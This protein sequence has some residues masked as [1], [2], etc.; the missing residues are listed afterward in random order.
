MGVKQIK[1]NFRLIF[2]SITLVFCLSCSTLDLVTGGTELV[3]TAYKVYDMVDEAS[4]FQDHWELLYSFGNK[5]AYFFLDESDKKLL[6]R[7]LNNIAGEITA[8]IRRLEKSSS[9]LYNDRYHKEK[10]KFPKFKVEIR[11]SSSAFVYAKQDRNYP[12]VIISSAMLVDLV[13][14]SYEK[15]IVQKEVIRR[16]Y[17]HA[18]SDELNVK[19]FSDVSI[20]RSLEYGDSLRFILSHE[21]IHL[22]LDPPL[23]DN[24]QDS[25]IEARAD[26]IG[27]LVTSEISFVIEKKRELLGIENLLLSFNNPNSTYAPVLN[28]SS[29][30]EFLFESNQP[31]F[32]KTT[33]KGIYLTAEERLENARSYMS[34]AVW[35]NLRTN[36]ET[37]F[38][39]FLN[40]LN[41]N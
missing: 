39:Y 40:N 3:S 37:T 19:L 33:D 29:G 34:K 10:S 14:T 41:Q 30:P 38:F 27:F 11:V 4:I 32:N 23:K 8:E 13:E 2:V 28:A 9:E 6:E 12:K 15:V 17:N 31:I 16:Q 36:Y 22:W 18:D 35:D 21:A 26:S 5:Q 24:E 20:P 7:D 25:E 1:K